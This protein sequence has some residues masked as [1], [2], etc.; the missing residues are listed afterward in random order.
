[1]TKGCCFVELFSGSQA[2]SRTAEGYPNFEG[3]TLTV[4]IDA[5]TMPDLCADILELQPGDLPLS[6]HSPL[7]VVW[8][9]PD[10]TQWS[11]ARGARNEFREAN[12]L[13]LS[14]DAENAIK[15]VKHTL[16]LIE[17]LNPTYWFLENPFHGALK[18]QDFMKKYPYYD[19]TYCS[20]DYPFQKKTRIWGKF[21]PDWLPLNNCS[22]GRH[23]NIKTH[24]DAKARSVIP[25]QLCQHVVAAC[26]LSRGRQITTLEDFGV[27]RDE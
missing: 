18:E 14:E 23:Q 15:L 6:P 16:Y 4:D 12:H 7:T 1:M 25:A 9:S 27:G 8:A 19:V 2:M 13:E 20:Y 5:S 10:C 21:P 3:R 22:H 11:Y 17:Q 24:K 26:I